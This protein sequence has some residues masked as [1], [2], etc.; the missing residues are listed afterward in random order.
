[1]ALSRKR[2]ES[3]VRYLVES[4]GIDLKRISAIGYGESRPL[5][6]NQTA[7][8]RTANRRVEIKVTE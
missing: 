7:E 4:G 8:G 2:A 1:M 5:K 3:V 6:T